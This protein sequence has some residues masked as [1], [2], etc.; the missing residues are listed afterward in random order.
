[1]LIKRVL[2]GVI[3]LSLSACVTTNEVTGRRQ[4]ITIPPSQDIAL[5]ASALSEVKKTAPVVT[6]GP[7]AERIKR[8]GQRI[9]A[10]SHAPNMEWEFIIIDEPVLNAWALPGGKIAV[11]SKM[12]ETFNTDAEIAAIL[13]HEVAH[14]VLRHGAEQV[15]RG[16][17]QNLA[18]AGLGVAVGATTEDAKTAQLAVALGSMAAQGFVQLPHSRAMELEADDVGTSYMAKA[19]FDPRASVKLWQ[20]MKSLKDGKQAPSP[21]FSTHPAD[22]QRIARLQTKMD[23]YLA[24]YKGAVRR[25]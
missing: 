23:V 4:L 16:Q 12:A 24:E 17:L 20:K 10:I 9:A 25:Y 1:M 2:L 8:I 22:D 7:Q 5:G 15:S 13:G 19:G 21:F 14:A 6:T 3:L 11:Y 18:I